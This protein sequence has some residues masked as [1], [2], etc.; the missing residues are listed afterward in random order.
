MFFVYNS[1]I[2]YKIPNIGNINDNLYLQSIIRFKC[3]GC[4]LSCALGCA[5]SCALTSPADLN[6]LIMEENELCED[7]KV[8]NSIL[9]SL[10]TTYDFFAWQNQTSNFN[11]K[12]LS[13][14][15]FTNFVFKL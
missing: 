1:G 11:N 15:F 13:T 14:Y 12:K 6:L 7:T 5:L 4:A 3:R 2:T 8:S 9:K 10:E